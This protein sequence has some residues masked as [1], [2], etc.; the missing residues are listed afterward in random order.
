MK[1]LDT[2]NK[3]GGSKRDA[4]R[5][6]KKAEEA[7]KAEEERQ[8]IEREKAEKEGGIS[9]RFRRGIQSFGEMRDAVEREKKAQAERDRKKREAAK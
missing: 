1:S 4:E 7:R 8:R 2:Y 5:A 3:S 6:K 9:G